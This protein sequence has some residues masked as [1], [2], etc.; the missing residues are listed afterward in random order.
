MN[1]YVNNLSHAEISGELRTAFEVHGTVASVTIIT[2]EFNGKKRGFG[3]IEMP[4]EIEAKSAIEALEGLTIGGHDLHL[5]DRRT[6]SSRRV[7]RDRRDDVKRKQMGERRNKTER[8][9]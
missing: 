9:K 4:D 1:V 8:R 3:I 5:S 7:S 2:D 6:V